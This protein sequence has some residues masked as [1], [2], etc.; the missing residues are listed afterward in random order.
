MNYQTLKTYTQ[1]LLSIFK[2]DW[3]ENNPSSIEYIKNRPFFIED[4][5]EEKIIFS[6]P[7]TICEL[8][9][10]DN[11]NYYQYEWLQIS[12][13]NIDIENNDIFF[14]KIDNNIKEL[15]VFIE[16][17]TYI[18]LIGNSEEDCEFFM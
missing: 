13:Q 2:K 6:L 9:N 14:I 18:M 12:S 11:N 3:K 8:P 1:G 16:D 4:E 5:L 10:E 15:N 17:D 7:L